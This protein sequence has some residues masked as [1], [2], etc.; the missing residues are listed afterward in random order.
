MKRICIFTLFLSISTAFSQPKD[1]EFE[2]EEPLNFFLTSPIRK[3]ELKS[4]VQGCF[5]P[6]NDV[7]VYEKHS[8]S[9]LTITNCS[10]NIDKT[11]KN[12]KPPVHQNE[13]NSNL[14]SSILTAINLNPFHQPSLHDFQIKEEDKQNYLAY[15]E[16]IVKENKKM[17][18]RETFDEDFFY[19]IPSMLDTL[20]NTLL[21][22][23]ILD[24]Q[25]EGGCSVSFVFSIQITNENNEILNISKSYCWEQITSVRGFYMNKISWLLPWKF[26][27]NGIVFNCHNI[28]FS[29]FISSCIPDDFSGK[30]VFDNSELIMSIAKFLFIGYSQQSKNEKKMIENTDCQYIDV[31]FPEAD[32]EPPQRALSRIKFNYFTMDLPKMQ[33][34]IIPLAYPSDKIPTIDS[35]FS[36]IYNIENKLRNDSLSEERLVSICVKIHDLSLNI[37]TELFCN[38]IKKKMKYWSIDFRYDELLILLSN[39]S[40]EDYTTKPLTKKEYKKYL[41]TIDLK[42]L[43][44]F[45]FYPYYRFRF[46]DSETNYSTESEIIQKYRLKQTSD[47][48]EELEFAE[49]IIID[50][51]KKQKGNITTD[52]LSKRKALQ[53]Y[54]DKDIALLKLLKIIHVALKNNLVYDC[55]YKRGYLNFYMR[56]DLDDEGWDY[57]RIK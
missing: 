23:I 9:T 27:F 43:K 19:S 3:I 28:E 35:L 13:I 42:A 51:A 54:F 24:Q 56:D 12:D 17:N 15:V 4:I 40:E 26:E 33:S 20:N 46:V 31:V 25:E 30:E 14:L 32:V 39:N 44:E 52:S 8:D 10:I 55:F 57:G 5:S 41:K 38:L 37:T 16:K 45:D 47:F 6:D 18:P 36:I 29:R 48:Q 1:G 53:I 7:I 21:S 34:D 22:N 2:P 50:F 49:R 11:K